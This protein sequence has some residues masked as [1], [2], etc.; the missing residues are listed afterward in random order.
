MK[1]RSEDAIRRK[2]LEKVATLTTYEGFDD[3][4]S[5]G[6]D[7]G[8][9][10]NDRVDPDLV[11]TTASDAESSGDGKVLDKSIDGEEGLVDIT[12]NETNSVLESTEQSQSQDAVNGQVL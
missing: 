5:E 7:E 11:I 1:I 2:I 3:E 9:D 12:M 6:E 4:E 8:A 10:S